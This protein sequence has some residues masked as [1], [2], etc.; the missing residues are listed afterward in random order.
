MVAHSSDPYWD[1]TGM[2]LEDQFPTKHA[3]T[4]FHKSWNFPYVPEISVMA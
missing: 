3:V 4:I 1:E 2:A